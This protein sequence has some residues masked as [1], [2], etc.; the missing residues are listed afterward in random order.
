VKLEL[1][2][3]LE[4]DKR[5]RFALHIAD[6]GQYLN[7]TIMHSAQ[8]LAS[9]E[10]AQASAL[11]ARTCWESCHYAVRKH[12]ECLERQMSRIATIAPRRKSF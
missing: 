8:A 4:V 6:D 7:E 11:T 10:S 3:G 2:Q 1:L 12:L 5:H 9:Y